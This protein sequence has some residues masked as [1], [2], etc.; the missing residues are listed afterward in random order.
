MLGKASLGVWCSAFL[1]FFVSFMDA[2]AGQGV[3]KEAAD[4]VFGRGRRCACCA[5][6]L[7]QLGFYSIIAIYLDFFCI[8][9]DFI[10]CGSVIGTITRADSS[11]N[12]GR[13]SR[14]EAISD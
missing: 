8:L 3:F 11:K 2:A 12:V 10:S 4:I 1:L 9:K 7:I 13:C 6:S 14:S 5:V